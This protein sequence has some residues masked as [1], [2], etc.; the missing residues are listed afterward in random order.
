M[1]VILST[2]GWSCVYQ[3]ALRYILPCPVHARIHTP[4]ADT[5][6][7]D[8]PWQTYTHPPPSGRHTPWQ[9]PPWADIPLDR[10]PLADIHT[11]PTFCQTHYPGRH[12]SGQ[13]SPPADTPLA[14]TPPFNPQRPLQQMVRILLE[15]FLVKG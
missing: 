11:Y 4:W 7:A 2:G 13:A 9:T 3:H 6:W 10:H 15:C 12:P 1:S 5:L 14:D 8:T